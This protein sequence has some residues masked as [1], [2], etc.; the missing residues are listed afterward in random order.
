MKDIFLVD[1]D[2]TILDFHASSALSL[3][4]AFEA[5]G[6]AWETRFADVFKVVNDG[7]WTKLEERKL[8][9]KELIDTRFS[10]YLKELN[11]R[12]DADEFNRRYLHALATH[13][14]YV[15]GAEAFLKEL[16]TLGRVYIVTNGTLR[17]QKSRFELANLY[18]YANGVFVSDAIGYDK[19]SPKYTEY[20]VSHIE[21]FQKERAVWVGDSLNAD[22][23]SANELGVDS[24]WFNPSG[25]PRK[26]N[27]TPTYEAKTF[28]EI[29]KIL[30]N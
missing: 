25:K 8:T 22:I 6:V 28:A 3:R 26:G 2:D 16:N 13:P 10:I 27:A 4:M 15:D 30:K 20:V 1:A 24:V 14:I 5:L 12:L 21:N 11:L 9:R 17:I 18:A 23:K 7:L 29:L 19:P